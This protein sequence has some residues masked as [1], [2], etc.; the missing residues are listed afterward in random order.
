M[1]VEN[2]PKAG[3]M[4]VSRDRVVC[5]VKEIVGEQAGIAPEHIEETSDLECDLAYDSLMM[6]ETVMELEEHFGITVPDDVAEKVRTVGDVVEGV[7][8]LL[9]GSPAECKSSKG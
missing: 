1:T 2:N 6:I 8:Q 5:G 9:R 3:A 4:A 7:W